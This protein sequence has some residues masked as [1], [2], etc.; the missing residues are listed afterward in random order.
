MWSRRGPEVVA[1]WTLASGP[2]RAVV[3]ARDDI[4]FASHSEPESIA[5]SAGLDA[6]LEALWFG[7]LDH[8]L[9]RILG[10]DRD[11]LRANLPGAEP[12]AE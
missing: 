7:S 8:I 1:L 6:P 10:Y 12:S 4:D 11:D 9:A 5:H 2:P 3:H